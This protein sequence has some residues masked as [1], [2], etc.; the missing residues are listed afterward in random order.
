MRACVCLPQVAGIV[1]NDESGFLGSM[2]MHG[3]GVYN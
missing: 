1:R 2:I 3:D